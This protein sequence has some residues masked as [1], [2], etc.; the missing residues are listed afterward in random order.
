MR[1]KEKK[2]GRIKISSQFFFSHKNKQNQKQNF[3][4]IYNIFTR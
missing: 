1:K 2:E 3:K 4:Y